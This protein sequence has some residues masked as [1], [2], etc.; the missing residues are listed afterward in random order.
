MGRMGCEGRP[1]WVGWGE[2]LVAPYDCSER[3]DAVIFLHLLLAL[4]SGHVSTELSGS[5][6]LVVVWGDVLLRI[7]Q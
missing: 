7:A 2:C 5:A 3:G 6:I 4:C 1:G